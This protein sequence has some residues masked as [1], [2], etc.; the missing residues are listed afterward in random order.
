MIVIKTT[1]KLK[2][3]DFKRHDNA[4]IYALYAHVIMDDNI[5]C[6]HIF[7]SEEVHMQD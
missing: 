1:Y 5:K 4:A 3:I 6:N 2:F 7:I